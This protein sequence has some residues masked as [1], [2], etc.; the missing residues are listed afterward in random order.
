M[1]GV[2]LGVFVFTPKMEERHFMST[3]SLLPARAATN[4]FDYQINC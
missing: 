4:Y 1:R 3:P 2:I